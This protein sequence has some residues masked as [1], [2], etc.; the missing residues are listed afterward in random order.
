MSE[1]LRLS[2]AH[3]SLDGIR[4]HHPEIHFQLAVTGFVEQMMVAGAEIH[5]LRKQLPRMALIKFLPVFP[6]KVQACQQML[7][8]FFGLSS[9][10]YHQ[11]ALQEFFQ[12][13]RVENHFQ[14]NWN[15]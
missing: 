11:T 14:P 1:V 10:A 15:H 12:S 3:Q 6:V 7:E 5:F 4:K 8:F 2:G 9:S 13:L